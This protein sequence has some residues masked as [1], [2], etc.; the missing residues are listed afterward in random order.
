M[1]ESTSFPG[2][3]EAVPFSKPIHDTYAL[4]WRRDHSLTPATSELVSMTR[5]LMTGFAQSSRPATA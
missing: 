1:F 2:G 4:I 5:Q 3:L